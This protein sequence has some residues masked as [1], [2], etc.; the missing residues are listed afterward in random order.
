MKNIQK[1]KS[2]LFV[3]A[4]LISSF[5]IAQSTATNFNCS[6]CNGNSH[7]LFTELNSGKVIVLVWVM[8]CISCINPSK[9]TYDAVQSYSVSN[10]GRVVFN[11]ID[12]Y[13]NTSC[14]TLSSWGNTNAM[15]A[16]VT[17]SNAAINPADY[18]N[19]GMPKI[20]VVGG[21][22]HS[23][24]YNED[25][26]A[27]LDG[28]KPAIDKALEASGIDENTDMGSELIVWTDYTNKWAT[29]V[30]NLSFTTNVSIDV[31]DITGKKIKTIS[32]ANQAAGK[33][34]TQIDI[35][36]LDSG[37]YFIN[38]NSVNFSGV[39]KFIIAN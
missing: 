17:F 25:N 31:I 7:D 12:D 2:L 16:A 30:Y 19:V 32:F 14:A 1:R 3:I 39:V 38:L 6:D 4:I 34:E 28:I 8:P 13:A 33:H 27:N 22:S 15:P 10:P 29:V 18:G 9:T 26:G 36:N 20:V 11:L 24:F 21:S 5:S 23:I 37:L 35:E